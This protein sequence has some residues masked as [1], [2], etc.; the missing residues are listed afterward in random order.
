VPQDNYGFA[1][2]SIALIST[3]MY[4]EHVL[5]HHRRMCD[6]L[7][8]TTTPRSVHLCG[9]A[10]RHF[11]TLRDELNVRHFDTGFPVDFGRVRRNLG[12]DVRING[13]P[14]VEFLRTATPGEVWSDVRRIMTSG[15][16]EGGRFML[17]EGNNLAPHTPLENTEALYSAGLEFGDISAA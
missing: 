12:P 6:T 1:D 2:D 16:L 14:H 13:G 3:A 17:R 7:G 15:V 4:R 5:P 9:D 8:T 11:V 10:T